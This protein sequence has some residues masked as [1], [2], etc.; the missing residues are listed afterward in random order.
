[1]PERSSLEDLWPAWCRRVDDYLERNLPLPEGQPGQLHT[2]MRYSSIGAGKRFRAALVYAAGTSLGAAEAALDV[3]ACAVEL[4]HAFSLVHDDLP[5]MDDDNLRRGKPT[6]H[7]AFD[8]ATAILAGDALQTQAF[9]ILASGLELSVTPSERLEMLALLARASGAAGLAGG[10][11]IDLQATTVD[12]SL[13]TVERMHAL[14]TGSLIRASVSLG[15]LAASASAEV[16]TTLDQFAQNLGLAYQVIDDVLDGTVDTP[17]LGKDSGSDRDA[18]KPTYLSILGEH[19]ARQFAGKLHHSASQI[20]TGAP[21]DTQL[22]LAL[23]RFTI[24]R[25]H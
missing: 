11:A 22:L 25:S 1:M 17:I 9:E 3:P 7:R 2:A 12:A 13:D 4:V 5:A 23:A 14:K 24:E 18:D 6:C 21:F 19:D 10:Q 20:L 16:L 8:E 15:A